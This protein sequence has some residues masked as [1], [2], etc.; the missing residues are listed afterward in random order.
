MKLCHRERA[1]RHFRGRCPRVACRA[2][3]G[4]A[5]GG[6]CDAGNRLLVRDSRGVVFGIDVL[7]AW[8]KDS[9]QAMIAKSQCDHCREAIEFDATEFE[10]SGETAHHYIGQKIICPHCNA[11][12]ILSMDK[13][14][15]AAGGRPALAPLLTECPACEHIISRRA[16]MCPNC[17]HAA[18]LRFRFIWEI[19]GHIALAGF[20][21]WIIIAVIGLLFRGK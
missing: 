16:L 4:G 21:F 3:R 2:E 12:T 10:R 19:M 13:S 20:I 9:L 18:G 1:G 15:R 5:T 17:G 7:P 11:S 6:D 14:E 8:V